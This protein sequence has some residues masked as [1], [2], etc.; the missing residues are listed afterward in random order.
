MPMA[1]QSL[2]SQLW[3]RGGKQTSLEFSLKCWQTLWRRHFSWQTVPSSCRSDG[4]RSVADRG[5][6]CQS[7]SQCHRHNSNKIVKPCSRLS[8]AQGCQWYSQCRGR[9]GN[10]FTHIIAK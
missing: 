10:H 7:Y 6:P 8:T 9:W 5:K 3:E 1:A 4:E 2:Y